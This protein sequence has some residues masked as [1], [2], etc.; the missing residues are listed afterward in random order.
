MLGD[1]AFLCTFSGM[2]AAGLIWMALFVAFGEAHIAMLNTL[3][4]WLSPMG[5]LGWAFFVVLSV[6]CSWLIYLLL[7]SRI[8]TRS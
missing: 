5:I 2:M 4:G 8:R 1:M 6:V 3:A 7:R